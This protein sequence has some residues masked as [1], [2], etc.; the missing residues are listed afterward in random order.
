MHFWS[1]E[2]FQEDGL[3]AAEPIQSRQLEAKT[4]GDSTAESLPVRAHGVQW[5]LPI[6]TR[7]SMFPRG[8]V[9]REFPGT[10]LAL[11][12]PK[13]QKLQYPQKIAD[14]FHLR[15]A[16]IPLHGPPDKIG[17]VF[18]GVSP[19]SEDCRRFLLL[20]PALSP[21]PPFRYLVS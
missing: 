3:P 5:P 4:Q 17:F 2:T 13:Q 8:T 20:H 6:K 10:G 21:Y 12:L 14:V 7:C 15:L 19:S 1:K 11:S 16:V 9:D 18:P